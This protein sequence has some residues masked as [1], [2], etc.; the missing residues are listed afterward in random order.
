M[1]ETYA[2]LSN[3][4]GN[5]WADYRISTADYGIP[6][7][8]WDG[9]YFLTVGAIRAKR[10]TTG[11]TWSTVA[12]IGA[13]PDQMAT[14][15]G[16]VLAINRTSIQKTA[17]GGTSW[18]AVTPTLAVTTVT[19]SGIIYDGVRYVAF[20]T[21]VVGATPTTEFF[22]S[23]TGDTFVSLGTVPVA[24]NCL[25]YLNNV[26]YF[27]TSASGLYLS[28]NAVTWTLSTTLAGGDFYSLAGVAGV[29]VVTQDTVDDTGDFVLVSDA[30]SGT[31]PPIGVVTGEY[32]DFTQS[33]I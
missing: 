27:I 23:D 15:G 33:P 19:R 28:S 4:G 29:G 8:I 20:F 13:A 24:C 14:A 25:T 6:K 12:N 21:G 18:T 10:S 3:D 7:V 9:T 32:F 1:P 31:I 2:L 16:S 26:Y 11:T 22:D 30:A 17:N 5:S